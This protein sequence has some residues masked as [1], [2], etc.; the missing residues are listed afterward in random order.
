MKYA[1]VVLV[2]LAACAGAG[3]MGTAS[4]QVMDGDTPPKASVV[5]VVPRPA[6][7]PANHDCA[8]MTGTALATCRELNRRA[9]EPAKTGA[10]TTNDCS[11]LAGAPLLSCRRLNAANASAPRSSTGESQDCGGQIGDALSAC[12]ALNG[13]PESS[14][15]PA[16]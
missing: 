5:P 6:V 3:L 8:G 13:E 12:R 7:R 4:A 11:G 9:D 15:Q 2:A 14:D 1:R 10:G 16:Q